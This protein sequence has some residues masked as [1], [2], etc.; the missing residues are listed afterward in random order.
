MDKLIVTYV[1]HACIKINGPFGGLLTDPWILN[2]PVYAF[3]TWKFPAA[4][5]PPAEVQKNIDYV[6]LSHPHEDHLHIPSLNHLSRDLKILLPEYADYPCLRAQTVERTFREMGFHHIRK[7]KPFETIDLGRETYF[8]LIPAAKQ[9]YWDWENSG[10][11]L[12]HQGE[13][14]LNMNDCPSDPELYREVDKRFG[15]IDI[16]FVVFAY[17]CSPV[18]SV[19]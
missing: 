19:A 5:M 12:E 15:E 6:Y 3:T 7:L 1:T 2:E 17:Q 13:K 16:G 11:V 14:I 8:T 18:V 4:I 9:K 10:F